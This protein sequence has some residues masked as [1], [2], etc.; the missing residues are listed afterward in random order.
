MTNH[1]GAGCFVCVGGVRRFLARLLIGSFLF[2]ASLDPVGAATGMTL[3]SRESRPVSEGQ[4]IIRSHYLQEPPAMAGI[5]R[6]ATT[7]TQ[8]VIVVGPGVNYDANRGVSAPAWVPSQATLFNG[9]PFDD[10]FEHLDLEIAPT[11]FMWGLL[12]DWQVATATGHGNV[13]RGAH[14]TTFGDAMAIRGDPTWT[15]YSVQADVKLESSDTSAGVCF[16]VKPVGIFAP[17]FLRAD[18]DC[19]QCY[20]KREPGGTTKFGLGA[21]HLYYNYF[22]QGDLWGWRGLGVGEIPLPGFDPDQ[23]HTI[24]VE[25]T[26]PHL[27]CYLDATPYFDLN[28]TPYPFLNGMV[29]LRV[30]R[31]SA[32]F[33]NVKVLDLR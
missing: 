22:A 11:P 8:E 25:A 21:L 10:Q 18:Y 24:K 9:I 7:V 26:G 23:W 19:Y 12:G 28:D 3:L 20:L 1:V 16:R 32:S 5:N 31:D 4:T 17:F 14:G 29:G 27:R 15:D 33:D 30:T 6:S 2:F 13:L